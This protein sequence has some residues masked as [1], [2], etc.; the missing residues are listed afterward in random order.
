M[1]A[2]VRFPD[3]FRL[4]SSYFGMSDYGFDPVDGWYHDGAGSRTSILDQDIGNPDTGGP[5]V[6]DRY[7]ARASNLAAANSRHVEVH[8]FVNDNETICPPVNDASFAMN[9]GSQVVYH[10]GNSASPTFEDFNG[11]GIEDPGER[12]LWPHGFPTAS[13]QDAAEQW[14][15]DRLLFGEIPQPSIDPS[16]TLRVA[17]FLRT[18]HFEVWPGDGQ[19]AA[20]IVTYSLGETS[21]SFLTE[22]ISSNPSVPL[23][24]VVKTEFM[25]PA[26]APVEA[27]LN[28]E[29][30]DVFPAGVRRVFKGMASG[31]LLEL[32][33]VAVPVPAGPGLIWSLLLCALPMVGLG[34]R[35]LR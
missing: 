13:Q 8:L 5:A 1:S 19:N 12:Q 23:S 17:G 33:Q 26:G 16:G 4:G 3:Y 25:A 11:N 14:Y 27:R 20:A 9:G 18:R 7:L 31:D 28:G 15:R 30:I 32:S 29:P 34:V 2:L 22:I 21:A 24:L 35:R 10:L 6:L